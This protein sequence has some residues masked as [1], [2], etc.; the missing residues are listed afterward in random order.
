MPFL[1]VLVSCLV[2]CAVVLHSGVCPLFFAQ[3]SL[4]C[5]S[6]SQVLPM[7]WPDVSFYWAMLFAGSRAGFRRL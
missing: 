1:S 2:F 3:I 4:R 6:R 7:E 5:D